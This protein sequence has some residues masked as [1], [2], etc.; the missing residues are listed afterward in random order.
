MMDA[1]S[2]KRFYEPNRLL[3]YTGIKLNVNYTAEEF[4]EAYLDWVNF[5]YGREKQWDAYCDVRDRVPRGT[6]ARIRR[7]HEQS[8]HRRIN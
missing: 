6:N 4:S 3:R 7:Q 8:H 1:Y 2:Y 5:P